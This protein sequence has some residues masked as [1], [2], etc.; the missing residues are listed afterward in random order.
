MLD[1]SPTAMDLH[2]WWRRSIEAEGP[3]HGMGDHSNAVVL[4]V[5]LGGDVSRLRKQQEEIVK[6]QAQN[7]PDLGNPRPMMR[8]ATS[9]MSRMRPQR[10]TL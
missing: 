3:G 5:Y 7:S 10:A 2:I 6:I 8:K 9:T 1:G 4:A